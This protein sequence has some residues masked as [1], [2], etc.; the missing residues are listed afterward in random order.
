MT[1][2]NPGSAP[3][4]NIAATSVF[5]GVAPVAWQDLDLSAVVGARKALVLLLFYNN[6]GDATAQ[7]YKTRPNGAATEYNYGVSCTATSIGDGE[8]CI[9]LCF[10]DAA[11]IVEWKAGNA[12]TTAIYIEVWLTP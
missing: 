9:L 8:A 5:N 11:G 7:Q 3:L 2:Y 6:S 10:T 4:F 1:L 12:K